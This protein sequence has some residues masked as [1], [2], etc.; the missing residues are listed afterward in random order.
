MSKRDKEWDYVKKLD[1]M[2]SPPADEPAKECKINHKFNSVGLVVGVRIK[3]S[4]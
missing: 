2:A 1:N 4:K 3:V